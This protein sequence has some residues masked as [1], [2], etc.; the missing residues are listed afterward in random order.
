[1]VLLELGKL[2]LWKARTV[3]LAR[4]HDRIHL[5]IERPD[6]RGDASWTPR[7]GRA[8]RLLRLARGEEDGLGASGYTQRELDAVRR[9]TT[10]IAQRKFERKRPMGK[11]LERVA[12]ADI[13]LVCRT[14]LLQLQVI[15]RNLGRRRRFKFI[16]VGR[17][18]IVEIEWSETERV[19]WPTASRTWRR[20]G[21][22]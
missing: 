14:E 22:P 8:L 17:R 19:P 7:K 4:A 6:G 12:L 5:G 11:Q 16:A 1:R 10:R 20:T 15:F 13:L 18:Q 9:T 21:H 3:Q 2:E